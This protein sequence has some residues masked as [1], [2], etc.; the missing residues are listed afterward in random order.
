MV[1]RRS[2][3][4]TRFCRHITPSLA[5]LP[6]QA[7]P[8]LPLGRSD[9]TLSRVGNPSGLACKHLGGATRFLTH[10]MATRDSSS[11]ECTRL[12]RIAGLIEQSLKNNLDTETARLCWFGDDDDYSPSGRAVRA[13][14]TPSL[15]S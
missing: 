11:P 4:S 14:H 10:A 12:L 9:A 6:S 13:T 7:I 2:I 5:N 15:A 3:G 8:S 1:R